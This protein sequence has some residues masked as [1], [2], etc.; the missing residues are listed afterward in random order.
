MKIMNSAITDGNMASH[1]MYEAEDDDMPSLH[2][3][4]S[5]I[6]RNQCNNNGD[7]DNNNDDDDD[8]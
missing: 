7:N 2:C 6:D 5:N 8:E 1:T 4:E 3:H